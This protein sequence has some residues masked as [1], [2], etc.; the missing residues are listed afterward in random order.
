M[1][2]RRVSRPNPDSGKIAE[3]IKVRGEQKRCALC[4]ER[5]LIL[6]GRVKVLPRLGP[7][8]GFGKSTGCHRVA[9][10]P[11]GLDSFALGSV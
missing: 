9:A 7:W 1:D 4:L 6:V 2:F 10:S 3:A 8:H 11:P 5:R